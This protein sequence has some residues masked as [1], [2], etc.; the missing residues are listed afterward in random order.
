MFEL[1][2]VFDIN[3]PSFAYY[4]RVS[5]SKVRLGGFVLVFNM[6]KIVIG[7]LLF[8]CFLLHFLTL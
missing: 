8:L 4:E 6:S 7:R 1:F 5:C 2:L 3:C